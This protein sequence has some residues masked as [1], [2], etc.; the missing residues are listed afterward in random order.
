MLL[1]N[2]EYAK[3]FLEHVSNSK[4]S[5]RGFIFHDSFFSKVNGS[6][7]D[8][9]IL[10]LS[11]AVKRGVN[12]E[13][14][15]NSTA[16]VEKFRRFNFKIKKAKHFKTMHSKAFLFDNK[17]LFVGSHNFT[18]NAITLNLEM[19]VIIQDVEDI[20][21]FNKYFTNIWSL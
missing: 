10:E 16:Q 7:I 19:S 9:Y 12:V 20:E 15:C 21:K 6:K 8:Q 3:Q 18:E 11:K 4:N 5:I 13:I 17:Y 1:I 2:G 14:L